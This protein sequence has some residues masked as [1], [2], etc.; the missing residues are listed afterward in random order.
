MDTFIAKQDKLEQFIKSFLKKIKRHQ[1]LQKAFSYI[2]GSFLERIKNKIH[3]IFI[4]MDLDL[5]EESEDT[6]K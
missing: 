2:I 6:E 1:Y 5:S 3:D 4:E